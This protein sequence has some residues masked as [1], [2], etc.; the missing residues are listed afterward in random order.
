MIRSTSPG[1]RIAASTRSATVLAFAAST[2]LAPGWLRADTA[3]EKGQV[4]KNITTT[5]ADAQSVNETDEKPIPTRGALLERTRRKIRS[6]YDLLNAGEPAKAIARIEELGSIIPDA[7]RQY[8]HGRALMAL[9]DHVRARSRFRSAIQRR[10][11]CGEFYYWLGLSY[12]QTGSHALAASS[13]NKAHLK[14]LETSALHEAWA[15]SLMETA[16]VLGDISRKQFDVPAEPWQVHGAIDRDGVLVSCV[17][18]EKNEWVIAPRDSAL[19]HAQQATAL[20]EDR[21]TAWLV[22]GETWAKAG[23]PDIAA[24]RFGRAVKLLKG[25]E[26]S[27][28]HQLWAECLYAAADYDGFIDHAK[29]SIQTS[30]DGPGFDLAEAY[31]RAATGHALIGETDKQVNCLKFA[32]ELD[33]SVERQLKLADALLATERSDEASVRLRDALAM[34]PSRAEKRQ[35]KQ[36]LVQVTQL[37]MPGRR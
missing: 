35:I 34:N 7:E 10:P 14:G 32:V 27:K 36:R 6:V 17:D 1:G 4:A 9:G 19:F 20:D 28:C 30:S 31:D 5:E 24:M 15:V 3:Q 37:S 23:F 16:D 22:A 18:P 11:R 2:L 8:L 21:G 13:F 25:P 33:P 12:Q 26:L 29:L